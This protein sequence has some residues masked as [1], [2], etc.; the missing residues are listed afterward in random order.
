[1]RAIALAGSLTLLAGSS[2][3]A[4]GRI[5]ARNQNQTYANKT[6]DGTVASVSQDRNGG[7]RV[8]LTNGMSRCP[9][10]R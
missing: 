1:M 4:Q 10:A 5:D 9:L 8:R 7:E 2:A 3:F 6:V